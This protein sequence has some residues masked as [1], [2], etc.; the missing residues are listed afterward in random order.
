MA[1]QIK[2]KECAEYCSKC[3]NS[4]D[5]ALATHRKFNLEYETLDTYTAGIELFGFEVKSIKAGGAQVDNA[6]VIVRGGEVYVIALDVAPY[7]AS[8]TK[9]DYD[10]NRTR[11]L[12]LKKSEI[13][14]LYKT[15]ETRGLTILIKSIYLTHGLIKCEV[16]VCKRLKKHD[17]R[18]QIKNRDL[19]KRDQD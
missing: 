15:G 16:V 5:M 3:Y 8:N 2:A 13:I 9:T 18:E 10:R 12:L 7:Q 17:K 14:D 11:R 19:K 4:K 1:L 6:K